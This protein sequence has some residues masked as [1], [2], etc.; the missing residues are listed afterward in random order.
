MEGMKEDDIAKIIVSLGMRQEH[1]TF[2][3]EHRKMNGVIRCG[4]VIR[5]FGG[6][7]NTALIPQPGPHRF[8]F[9]C[10]SST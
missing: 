6:W 2:H 5:R 4:N 9:Q 3:I 1:R 7:E 10:S 8:D